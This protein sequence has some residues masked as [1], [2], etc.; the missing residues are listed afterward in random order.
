MR[1]G[2][3]SNGRTTGSKAPDGYTLLLFSPT[4]AINA[5]LYE[6]LNY[7]FI[8]DIA[9][10]AG[11][12]RAPIV[13][14]VNPSVPAKSVPEFI[15]YAKAN[16]GQLNMG[17][18]GIG[19][20]LH[21]A[22]ELFK[23]MAGINMVHVP[24]R[25]S[26]PMLT[27]LLGGQ[28]QFAFDGITSSIEY[29]RAGKLRALAVT[30]TARADVLPDIPTEGEFIPGFEESDW[31]GVGAPKNTPTAII[32]KL[33]REINAAL[34]DPKVKARLAD[35]GST[36]MPLSPADFGRFIAAETEKWGKVIRAANIKAE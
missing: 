22:G 8:R 11:L 3:P 32:A 24:Y 2:S 30:A 4:A 26:G 27:G 19:T 9:P 33:N 13:M 31:F 28:V 23:M 21:V 34:V 16:P 12:A 20:P 10:V 18:A 1:R 5:T 15:A 17:S 29:I 6:R 36:P 35:F 14:E 25:G 7:N